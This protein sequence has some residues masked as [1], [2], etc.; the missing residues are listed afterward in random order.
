[1]TRANDIDATI[2]QYRAFGYG[3]LRGVFG[4]D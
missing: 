2:A 1:M 3:V 4:A